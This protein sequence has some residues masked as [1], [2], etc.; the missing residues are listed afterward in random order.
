MAC[1]FRLSSFERREDASVREG[2]VRVVEAR[3]GV[4]SRRSRWAH[5]S[6]FHR[7]SNS[8]W[9]RR[10]KRRDVGTPQR[11]IIQ[12]GFDDVNEPAL[13]R[14]S[15]GLQIPRNRV[16]ASSN[17]I[18]ESQAAEEAAARALLAASVG[19]HEPFRPP[20]TMA[21]DQPVRF[22]VSHPSHPSRLASRDS[23][24]L[25]REPRLASPRS[26]KRTT[27][28]PSRFR[29]VR[30]G[31]RSAPPPRPR[32]VPRIALAPRHA[33]ERPATPAHTRASTEQKT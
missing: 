15:L 17:E 24:R 4:R 12:S 11:M 31:M 5:R 33:S 22:L 7:F 8:K 26:P 16:R 25:R 3:L 9:R 19:T 10:E 18:G 27:R 29:E 13:F 6:N 14:I 2:G 21:D 32:R 23:R 1:A 28:D 20:A 30:L